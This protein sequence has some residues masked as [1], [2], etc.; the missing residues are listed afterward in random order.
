MIAWWWVLVAAFGGSSFGML[1]MAL[2]VSLGRAD[3][4]A[5]GYA[6]GMR[7]GGAE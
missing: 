3:D 6:A 1:A 2:C 4:F 5:D 7:E